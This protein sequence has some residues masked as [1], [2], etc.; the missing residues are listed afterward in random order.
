MSNSAQIVIGVILL[1][2]AVFLIIAILMQDSKNEGLSSA[3]TGADNTSFGGKTKSKKLSGT[4][5]KVTTIV[6][7]CFVLVVILLT[8]VN[9][10]LPTPEIDGTTTT[11]TAATTTP[12]GEETTSTTETPTEETTPASATP[13]E[14]TPTPTESVTPSSATETQVTPADENA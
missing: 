4:L 8:T 10:S 1:I 14:E 11:T 5:S 7:I 2:S 12:A 9:R 6:A 13:T 3:L